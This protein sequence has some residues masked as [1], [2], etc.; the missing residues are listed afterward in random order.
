[1][2]ATLSK[3]AGTGLFFLFIFLFGFWLSRSGRPYSTI[4]FNIHKLIALAAVIFLI[5]TVYR[6]S[7]A[8][9]L[10]P[11]QIVTVGITALTV[12]GLF[13][14]GALISIDAAGG[15]GNASQSTRTAIIMIHRVLPYLAVLS[16]SMTLYLLLVGKQ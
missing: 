14:T 16:T 15:L 6:S 3:I 2:N 7:R 10:G 9:S 11:A 12:I 5:V 4:L 1:M 8:A 13:A